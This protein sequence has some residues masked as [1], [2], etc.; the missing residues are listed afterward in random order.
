[1]N[2]KI[3]IASLIIFLSTASFS[4]AVFNRP[5]FHLQTVQEV[6]DSTSYTKNG[7]GTINKIEHITRTTVINPQEVSAKITAKQ[8]EV[9]ALSQQKAVLDNVK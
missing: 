1:M 3:I 5:G 4:L 6:V 8:Q 7:D 9:S 2:K